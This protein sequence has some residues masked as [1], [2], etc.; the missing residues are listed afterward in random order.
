ML[1]FESDELERTEEFLSTHY[2]PM[3]IGSTTKRSPARIARTV[4]GKHPWP[5]W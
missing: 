3:R 5:H 2:A 1:V 4:A